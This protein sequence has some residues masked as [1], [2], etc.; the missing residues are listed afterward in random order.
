MRILSSGRATASPSRRCRLQIWRKS[1]ESATARSIL[2]S[3][4]SER[5]QRQEEAE[6]WEREW[7]G[8]RHAGHI[9]VMVNS[10]LTQ[11]SRHPRIQQTRRYCFGHNSL[12]RH[13]NGA[14]LD[15]LE[16]RRRRH[17]FGSGP[18]SRG[19]VDHSVW[20]WQGVASPIWANLAMYR[21]G[22]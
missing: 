2:R 11:L 18:S 8:H 3:C 10:F 13:Q 7:R 17:R 19:S 5:G 6:R 9:D 21:V 4:D 15:A 12:I 16:R 14:F 20:P 1:E 22:P